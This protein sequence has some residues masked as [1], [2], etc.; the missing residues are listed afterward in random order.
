MVAE[1]IVSLVFLR[2]ILEAPLEEEAHGADGIEP[3]RSR[4][5]VSTD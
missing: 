4:D 3:T 2:K 5:S 1:L